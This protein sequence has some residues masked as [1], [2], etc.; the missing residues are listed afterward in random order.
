VA[1]RGKTSHLLGDSPTPVTDA[2]TLDSLDDNIILF[3]MLITMEPKIQDLV[4]H[5]MTV[6]ELC[7]F[8]ARSLRKKQQHQQGLGCYLGAILKKTE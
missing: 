3:Q 4:L 5:C 6:K 7:D 2:W 1:D 8:F